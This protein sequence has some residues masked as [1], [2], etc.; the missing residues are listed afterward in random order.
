MLN[1]QIYRAKKQD[2]DEYLYGFLNAKTYNLSTT[3]HIDLP[4][5]TIEDDIGIWRIYPSTLSIHF[6]DML[7]SD[8]DR[9]LPNGEKD[10]RIFASLSED[11]KGGDIISIPDSSKEHEFNIFTVIYDRWQIKAINKEDGLFGFR[12]AFNKKIIGIQQ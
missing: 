11:G 12:L 5:Y 9:L 6:Q 8:S 10:L 4:H 3:H 2:S 7:A 1:I